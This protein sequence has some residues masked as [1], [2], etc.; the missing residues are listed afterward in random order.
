MNSFL[1]SFF[2]PYL[3]NQCFYRITPKNFF[4]HSKEEKFV[5]KIFI[6]IVAFQVDM[7][8]LQKLQI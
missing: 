2:I 6:S 3:N 7:H 8:F 1:Y 4:N 5:S